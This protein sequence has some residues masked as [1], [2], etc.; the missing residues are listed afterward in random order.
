M[1]AF[2]VDEIHINLIV[3]AAIDLGLVA[4]LPPANDGVTI[5][6]ANAEAFG[7][8]LWAENA[9]SVAYRYPRDDHG[10]LNAEVAGYR[11]KR[12]PPLTPHAAAKIIAAYNYQACETPDYD[13]TP[14]AYAVA[15]FAPLLPVYSGANERPEF[16]RI[17]WGVDDESAARKCFATP[18]PPAIT[19]T[20]A[21]MADF[22]R[23]GQ[24]PR[25]RA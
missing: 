17:P 21:K 22:A 4:N 9:R 8:M 16:A 20:I 10:E 2:L 15:A 6:A 24:G 12:Y 7:R 1:S 5:T 11:F 13:E 3:T 14:A 18:T 23:E 19:A 25:T